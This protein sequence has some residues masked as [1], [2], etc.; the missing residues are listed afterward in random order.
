MDLY[1]LCA[2]LLV[3]HDYEYVCNYFSESDLQVA[4]KLEIFFFAMNKGFSFLSLNRIFWV[5]NL[6]PLLLIFYQEAF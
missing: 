4:Y 2:F 5:K 6:L 1:L 3:L